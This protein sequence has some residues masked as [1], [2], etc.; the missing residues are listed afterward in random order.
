MVANNYHWSIK[1]AT[2]KSSSDKYNI[3]AL[4]LLASKVDALY[5]SLIG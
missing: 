5:S 2:S 1:Q 3:D 4:D